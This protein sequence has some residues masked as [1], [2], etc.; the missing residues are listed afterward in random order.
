MTVV[1]KSNTGQSSPGGQTH[2]QSVDE[3]GMELDGDGAQIASVYHEL[4]GSE[5]DKT[6]PEPAIRLSHTTYAYCELRTG[7]GGINGAYATSAVHNNV[8]SC[9][10]K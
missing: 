6:R 4:P 7:K 2:E 8:C 9:C 10:F 1:S 3:R 5:I